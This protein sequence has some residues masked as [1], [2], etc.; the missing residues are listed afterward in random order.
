MSDKSTSVQV[1]VRIRPLNEIEDIE[2]S[3]MCISAV[4]GESQV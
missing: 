2:D 4:P 1:A 3:S